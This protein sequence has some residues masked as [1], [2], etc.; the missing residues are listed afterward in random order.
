MY[1]PMYNTASYIVVHTCTCMYKYK[2]KYKYLR[3]TD[4]RIKYQWPVFSCKLA[5]LQPYR[6]TSQ[7]RSC[8]TAASPNA[9]AIYPF[10]RDLICPL[11]TAFWYSSMARQAKSFFWGL[12]RNH[13]ACK[14]SR[15]SPVSFVMLPLYFFSFKR[16]LFICTYIHLRKFMVMLQQ[17]LMLIPAH[18]DG[19]AWRQIE[20]SHE[21]HSPLLSPRGFQERMGHD[22]WSVESE[23]IEIDIGTWNGHVRRDRMSKKRRKKRG[24]RG[25]ENW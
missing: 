6:T 15:R 5:R 1:M 3:S 22:L 16:C 18:L 14:T 10:Y 21:R 24:F 7:V 12:W 9:I 2:Y 17:S 13:P 25:N 23:K 4:A 8:Q 20:F 19:H 11:S